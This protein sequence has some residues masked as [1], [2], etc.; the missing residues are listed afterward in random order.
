MKDTAFRRRLSGTRLRDDE[1]Y[2]AVAALRFFLLCVDLI[3]S[4]GIPRA[5]PSRRHRCA[6]PHGLNESER[7]KGYMIQ[8][9]RLMDLFAGL[10]SPIILPCTRRRC[11]P[12]R[13]KSCAPPARKPR[14]DDTAVRRSAATRAIPYAYFEGEGME[15]LPSRAHGLRGARLRQGA[16]RVPRVTE[17]SPTAR[18]CSARTVYPAWPDLR[19][20]ASGE[21]I[22][23]KAPPPSRCCSRRRRPT[24]RA[25]SAMILHPCARKKPI[26]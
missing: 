7:A 23:R 5:S 10:V 21:G 9:K 26:F 20:F 15:P 17:L 2:G 24:A 13:R 3:Q 4:L 18:P 11:A 6:L 14:E 16:R 1:T 25:F 22:R 8:Q 12:G 19:R